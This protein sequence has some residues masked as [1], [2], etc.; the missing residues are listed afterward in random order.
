MVGARPVET[1]LLGNIHARLD[2]LTALQGE[3]DEHWGAEDAIYRFWHGSFK[4]YGLQ[5]LTQRVVDA[6]TGLCPQGGS[7]NPWFTEIVTAGTGK[8]FA[9][10]HNQ[11]WVLHTRPIVDAYFHSR[12]MLDMVIKYGRE[13]GEP[14]DVLPS[15]WAAVLYLYQIR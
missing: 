12:F 11:D 10:E 2:V 9:L 15:G 1:E 13:L 8:T 5:D 3:C 14:P 6:L 7:V 4:V